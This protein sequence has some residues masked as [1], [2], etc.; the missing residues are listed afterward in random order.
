MPNSNQT[1]AFFSVDMVDSTK[2][3]RENR[4]IW[5]RYFRAF[6]QHFPAQIKGFWDAAFKSFDEDKY[7]GKTDPEPG[8]L[9]DIEDWIAKVSDRE[10]LEHATAKEGPSEW[11]S[12]G[13]EII[14]AKAITHPGELF[15]SLLLFHRFMQIKGKYRPASEHMPG[16]DHS[17]V[18]YVKVKGTVWLS[19]VYQFE[20][21]HDGPADASARN[22]SSV[23]R[24]GEEMIAKEFLGPDIDEGF[25]VA[26]FSES[27]YITLS[28]HSALF[29]LA[30]RSLFTVGMDFSLERGKALKGLDTKAKYPKIFVRT[31]KLDE[32]KEKD[33]SLI[34]QIYS[35]KYIAPKDKIYESV[36]EFL[37]ENVEHLGYPRIALPNGNEYWLENDKKYGW[38][39]REYEAEGGKD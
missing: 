16:V 13:D 18:P 23:V 19:T 17:K 8:Y 29:F 10:S 15:L 7:V 9:K 28:V 39:F 6:S 14:F 24:S 32:E 27:D 36:L 38:R 20:E 5:P 21:K 11:K 3:K 35:K 31:T 12:L 37:E 22:I 34:D 2:F 25:R 26:T 4:E 30:A 1:I 33:E